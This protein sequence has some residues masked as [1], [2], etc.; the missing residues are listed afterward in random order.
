MKRA[1]A[2]FALLALLCLGVVGCGPSMQEIEADR[3]V[4]AYYRGDFNAAIERLQPL[5]EETNENFVLNNMRLGA[6]ALAAGDLDTAERAYFQAYEALNAAGVNNTA[7]TAA[8]VFLNERFKVWL[9]EPYERAMANFHLG[10]VYYLR[11]DFA[12][13]RGAFENALFKLRRYADDDDAADNFREQESTFAVAHYMLGRCW[14]Q[15][16][17]EDLAASSF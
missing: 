13:A 5:S 17:R 8:T 15:L 16:G 6:A 1:T 11:G 12:N 3:A 7:R 2:I 10:L 4:T 9:G 14:L